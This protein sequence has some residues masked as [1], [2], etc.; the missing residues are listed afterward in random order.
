L[1]IIQA[2][3]NEKKRK[4]TTYL[5]VQGVSYTT[6]DSNKKTRLEFTVSPHN[7][8]DKIQF[9]IS[10]P[11]LYKREIILIKR[12]SNKHTENNIGMSKRKR[13][14]MESEQYTYDLSSDRPQVLLTA[15][16]LGYVQTSQFEIVI[17]NK[18]NEPL[19]IDSIRCWQLAY[20]VTA[21]LLKE[22]H[23]QFYVGDSILSSPEY[24]VAFFQKNIPDSLPELHTLSI[25]P[26]NQQAIKKLADNDRY[27]VWIGLVVLL[28]LL[29]W[30]TLGMAKKLQTDKNL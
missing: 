21:K 25:A 10:S 11:E 13:S 20:G 22:K 7:R 18:D 6:K 29:T 5:P 1:D 30:L 2:G 19:K 17:D 27:F 4:N 24:D 15:D 26:I 3:Y 14:S 12:S 23:Y 9:Y 16:M 8:I 28:A